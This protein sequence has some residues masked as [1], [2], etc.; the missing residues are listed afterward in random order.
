[1]APD[2]SVIPVEQKALGGGLEGAESTARET[3]A[4]MPSMG[5]PDQV[6]NTVKPMADARGR[7]MAQNDGHVA[8]AVSIHRDSI[9]GAQYRLNSQPNWQALGIDEGYAEELQLIVES[10]FN[11]VAE[12]LDC[13]FDASRKNT[14]TGLVRLGVA[15]QTLSG[16][17]LAPVEWMRDDPLAPFN[18]AI[19][20]ISP[21]RLS[22]P[23]GVADSRN[24]RRGVQ[25]N[26]RGAPV[27]YHI[28]RAY[29]TEYYEDDLAYQWKYVE[30]K[31]PWGRRQVIHIFEPL[32]PSQSRGVAEMVAALKQMKMTKKFQEIVLQNA[33]VNASY[34]A[35]IES[36]L[37]SEQV[38]AALGAN[39]Q[40]GVVGG[41][42]D[43]LGSY[44]TMLAAYLNNGK[45][46]AIDG[47]KIPHLFPGTKLSMKPIGT[48]GG[49][50][51]GFEESL[52][53]HIAAALGISYEEFSRDFTKT[54]YSSARASMNNTWK[55]MQAKK[56]MGA[57]RLASEIYAL[58]FEEEWNAGNI[59]RPAGKGKSW[60]YEP[61]VKDCLTRATWIGASRGQI[62]ELKETQAAI[63]RINSGLSTFEK[64]M[65]RLGEDYREVFAQRGRE[66]KLIAK[67]GLVLS[68]DAQ[69]STQG[70]SSQGTLRGERNGESPEQQEE[71][72][73]E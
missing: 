66:Q 43:Y 71:G 49:V 44:M 51:T 2:I 24:L 50:G 11:T 54:N 62:D 21:D 33:V 42:Q 28:R 39:N 26:N 7:D 73:E 37:P 68:S 14:F 30:A 8:G 5:S 16:E 4:W 25:M 34:A 67:L 70:A 36:E 10:R 15:T 27:G 47:A 52:L 53:R 72:E 58:W 6:I 61:L 59:P 20:L 64:E 18:T 38:F 57:D 69:R 55:S 22:N 9:V 17:I 56:R 23:Q 29:P 3:A 60:F 40:N 12:S 45:N 35:A 65:A 1:M 63:L 32:L 13:W 46:I 19:Q 31:K 48:P 41:M